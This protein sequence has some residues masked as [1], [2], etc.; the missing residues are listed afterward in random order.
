MLHAGRIELNHCILSESV[1]RTSAKRRWRRYWEKQ[2]NCITLKLYEGNGSEETEQSITI[3][4]NWKTGTVWGNLVRWQDD[5]DCL[6]SFDE[7]T[8]VFA[9]NGELIGISTAVIARPNWQHPWLRDER[10]LWARRDWGE[11]AAVQ[12]LHFLLATENLAG[13]RLNP[14]VQPMSWAHAPGA[15]KPW[16][17]LIV[18]SS[19][20]CIYFLRDWRDAGAGRGL[21]RWSAVSQPKMISAHHIRNDC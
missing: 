12:A 14:R 15:G 9:I 3:S 6:F 2:F 11:L 20:F 13:I 16:G 1:S 5:S 19:L 21:W 4:S 8:R 18:L 17:D 10:K 7:L